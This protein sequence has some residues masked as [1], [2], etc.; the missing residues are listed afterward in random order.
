MPFFS[1]GGQPDSATETDTPKIFA[2]QSP[3]LSHYSRI[4]LKMSRNL[5]KGEDRLSQSEISLGIPFRRIGKR[6]RFGRY[7]SISYQVLILTFVFP[8][9]ATS[10]L[11]FLPRGWLI[12]TRF[13]VGWIWGIVC[14]G[15]L[16]KIYGRKLSPSQAKLL[17]SLWTFAFREEIPKTTVQEGSIE[18]GGQIPPPPGFWRLHLLF[19]SAELRRLRITERNE[20]PNSIDENHIETFLVVRKQRRYSS[21]MHLSK[22]TIT[23]TSLHPA[24]TPDTSDYRW[25][26]SK[27]KDRAI[28]NPAL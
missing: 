25:K 5:F 4:A 26:C 28:S 24:I 17:I 7:E 10:S 9:W 27:E 1:G 11:R 21:F 19:I 8:L 16:D 2:Q 14:Q 13:G 20:H 22:T 18:I 23:P 15:N 6:A 3:P 12:R